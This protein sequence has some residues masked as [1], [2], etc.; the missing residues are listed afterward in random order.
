[1]IKKKKSV[2]VSSFLAVSGWKNW[3]NKHVLLINFQ[4]KATLSLL[5]FCEEVFSGVLGWVFFV[6]AGANF[7]IQ[8][9]LEA[10]RK[11]RYMFKVNNRG[12]WA[13]YEICSKLTA[14]IPEW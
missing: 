9:D 10:V 2:K 7:W 4:K 8:V 3:T 12:N 6:L 1:M 5:K 14:K 11:K 13:M